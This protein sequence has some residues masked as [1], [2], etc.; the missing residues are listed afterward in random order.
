M[1]KVC[2]STAFAFAFGIALSAQGAPATPAGPEGGP[3]LSGRWNRESVSGDAGT[4]DKSSWGSRVDIDHSGVDVTVRPN[5]GKPERHRLD[6]TETADVL[7]VDGCRNVTR[8][9]KWLAGPDRVTI[10][11]W[12]VTK[13]ACLHG[14]VEDEPFVFQTGPIDVRDARGGVRRLESITV[15]YREGDVLTV[16][17]TRATPGGAPTNTTT[18]YRK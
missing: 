2:A 13:P 1:R 7:S 15:V 11:T 9:T 4:A 12:L 5:S 14:E 3:D 17:T 6:G 10:T 16:D 8:I 18:T